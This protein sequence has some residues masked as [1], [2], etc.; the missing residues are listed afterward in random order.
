[1]REAAALTGLSEG[2]IRRLARRGVVASRRDNV[3]TQKLATA[4]LVS[5]TSLARFLA[6]QRQPA[7]QR[8]A[9]RVPRWMPRRKQLWTAHGAGSHDGTRLT[10]SGAERRAP[11]TPA[12]VPPPYPV[13]TRSEEEQRARNVAAQAL[14]DEWM[15]ASPEQVEEQRET[16]EFLVNHLDDERAGY[17]EIFPNR[18]GFLREARHGATER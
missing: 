10:R 13:L 18:E 7:L 2:H 14:L 12:L 16:L 4:R 17:R 8:M 9:Q 11:M 5:K 1:V 15:A 3:A 6:R